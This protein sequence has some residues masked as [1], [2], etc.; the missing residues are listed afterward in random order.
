[1]GIES[2]QI[3]LSFNGDNRFASTMMQGKFLYFLE[4]HSPLAC[5]PVAAAMALLK[6]KSREIAALPQIFAFVVTDRLLSDDCHDPYLAA[7]AISEG[8]GKPVVISISGKG[9]NVQRAKGILADAKAYGLRNFL[10]VTGDCH[11]QDNTSLRPKKDYLDSLEILQ[12]ARLFG[13]EMCLGATVNPFKYTPEDQCLQYAKMIRKIKAGVSYL[14]SQAGWDMKKAQELQ[15]FLQKRE[16]AIMVAARVC[17][18]S[19]DDAQ[20]LADGYRPGIYFSI[21]MGTAFMQDAQSTPEEFLERQLRRAAK[22]IVGYQKLGYGGVQLSGLRDP[23]VLKKLFVLITEE[24]QRSPDYDAWLKD[25]NNAYGKCNPMPGIGAHYL[26]AG[27]QQPEARDYSTE[28]NQLAGTRLDP[29]SRM[30]AW[31]ACLGQLLDAGEERPSWWQRAI[32]AVCR[33]PQERL[34]QQAQCLY[35]DN[36][37]CP[38]G[39]RLGPCGGSQYDGKCEDGCQPCFFQ[40]VVRVAAARN[41]FSVLEGDNDDLAKHE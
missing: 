12:A 41:Q 10:A 14:V 17:L 40:R 7:A 35:L 26:F 27:L 15:W 24:E 9:S 13:P 30:D 32:Q 2:K 38:K 34:Q 16:L 21:P 39:L 23:A 37:S 1:M 6:D 28:K 33:L 5:Q 11:T 19:W 29:P 36:S 25:W 3:N 20:Q 8:T 18:L 4:M 31:R 22:Q